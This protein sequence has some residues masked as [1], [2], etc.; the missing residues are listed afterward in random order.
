MKALKIGSIAIFLLS[1]SFMSGC[2][3]V[4]KAPAGLDAEAKK[5]QPNPSTSQVYV[6]RHEVLGA[7]LS[8]PVTVDGKLAGKT[9]SKSY[10]KFDLPAGKHTITSQ[11]DKSSI[12]VETKLGEI[13][14]IWQEVKMGALSGGSKLQ[15]V[16]AD[17]G[18]K[19]VSECKL[20]TSEL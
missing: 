14:F 16:N 7:A 11:G 9:G 4:N 12:D 2:A 6:Y 18:K 19:D 13:Y 15:V 1:I 20:I 3:S 8:M 17:K 10:F 5:F